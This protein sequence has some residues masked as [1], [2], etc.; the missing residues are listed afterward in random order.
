MTV[1]LYLDSIY[2]MQLFLNCMVLSLVKIQLGISVPRKRIWLTAAGMSGLYVSLFLLPFSLVWLEVTGTLLNVFGLCLFFLPARYRRHRRR[3]LLYGLAD[4]FVAS[5]VLRIVMNWWYAL[6]GGMWGLWAF[7]MCALALYEL[8]AWS[9][10]HYKKRRDRHIYPV[11][12]LSAG[13]KRQVLAL[14]DTGNGLTEPVSRRPVCLVEEELLAGLT[15]ENPLFF[16]AIP[17]HTVGCD[18]GLLY[19]IEIPE[20]LIDAED[21]VHSVKEVVC[22]GVSKPLSPKGKYQM[23]LHPGLF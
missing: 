13:Q 19:G 14:Y 11:T 18:E 8:A 7:L 1:R 15:L 6:T 3:M 12:I 20:L 2:M 10:R 16:M 22:A 9:L 21:G 4:T 23:I 17:F 5:G